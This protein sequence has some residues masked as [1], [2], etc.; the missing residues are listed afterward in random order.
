MCVF[1]KISHVT[2]G[3]MQMSEFA[4]RIEWKHFRKPAGLA[5]GRNRPLKSRNIGFGPEGIFFQ[6]FRKFENYSISCR[7]K[8][9]L[10]DEHRSEVNRW[11]GGRAILRK[12]ACRRRKARVC[13]I[14]L[15]GY[16]IFDLAFFTVGT[17]DLHRATGNGGPG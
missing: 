8:L 4:L 6:S 11:P 17:P 14:P 9:F 1:L 2:P 5:S 13:N 12:R 10:S 3:N 15:A 16:P 7:S